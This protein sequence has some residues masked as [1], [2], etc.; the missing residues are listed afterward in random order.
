MINA[1]ERLVL[2]VVRGFDSED[3]DRVYADGNLL[4]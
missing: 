2:K 1:F 4:G 3:F